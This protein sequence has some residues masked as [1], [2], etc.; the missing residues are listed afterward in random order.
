MSTTAEVAAVERAAPRDSWALWSR[1]IAAILRIEARKNFFGKRALLIYLLA[2][3]PV[4]LLFA[5][6]AFGRTAQRLADPGLGSI[7][8]AYV[9]EVLVLRAVVFFGCAWIFMNLFRGEIV[10]RS[11]HYYLLSAVRREVLV[12]GKYLS[13]LLASAVLFG[14]TT[15]VCLALYYAP[16]GASAAAQ[17]LVNGPGLHQALGYVFV[18]ALACAGYGAVFL[19]VG[20]LFRN[21]IIPALA[22]YGWEVINFLLPPVLKKISVI[23]YLQSLSPVPVPEGPFAVLA[24]PTPAWIGV[25][26][27]LVVTALVLW[28]AAWRVRRL[29]IRY[30]GE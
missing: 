11:L 6:V 8:F 27:F 16:R 13:G 15:V 3:L 30:G 26:G 28:F 19:A 21:P 9:Y 2:A 1:Q 17:H 23:H 20:L 22:I 4:L 12:A 25:P 10:D 5:M 29:E 14:G 18:T 24:D 7:I